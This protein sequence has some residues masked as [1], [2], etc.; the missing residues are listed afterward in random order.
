MTPKCPVTDDQL[1][2]WNSLREWAALEPLTR[3]E[4]EAS[5]EEAS[6]M[7]RDEM[8]ERIR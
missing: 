6:Q 8:L 4:A 3:E 7:S 5:L 2:R 1:A